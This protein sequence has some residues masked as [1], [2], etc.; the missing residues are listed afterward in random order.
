MSFN[1]ESEK[2]LIDLFNQ[3]DALYGDDAD[4][5]EDGESL[6]IE[7][8]NG[9]IWLI[10]IQSHHQEV[11]LSSPLTGAHHYKLMQDKWLNTRDDSE[12]HTVLLAELSLA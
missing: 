5:D 1:I 2:L 11:W 6:T 4:I 10:N 3:L 8:D 7:F 12:L 9:Q